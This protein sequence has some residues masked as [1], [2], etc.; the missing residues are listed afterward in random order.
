MRRGSG[1]YI[2]RKAGIRLH[3]H[4]DK[5]HDVM[6]IE[7]ERYAGNFFRQFGLVDETAVKLTIQRMPNGVLTFT[8]E[9]A[10]ADA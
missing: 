6:T 4:Y 7:G 1:R 5:D 9:H 3:Y 8:K 2:G 10:D